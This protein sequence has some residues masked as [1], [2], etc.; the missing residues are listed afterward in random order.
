MQSQNNIHNDELI[1]SLVAKIFALPDGH[2]DVSYLLRIEFENHYKALLEHIDTTD[3]ANLVNEI[4][5]LAENFLTSIIQNSTIPEAIQQIYVAAI[6]TEV[7]KIPQTDKKNIKKGDDSKRAYENQI[8]TTPV[9]EFVAGQYSTSTGSP[10][11]GK[12]QRDLLLALGNIRVNNNHARSIFEN[13][14][15]IIFTTL[16]QKDKLIAELI[17]K[18]LEVSQRQVFDSRV[19]TMISGLGAKPF[20]VI[21]T[22]MYV[23]VDEQSLAESSD[24]EL[25]GEYSLDDFKVLPYYIKSSD[26]AERGKLLKHNLH[27]SQFSYSAA[28]SFYRDPFLEKLKF[29]G[30]EAEFTGNAFAVIG[31]NRPR[32]L[33][34]ARNQALYNEF[35]RITTSNFPHE[36]MGF[37]WDRIWYKKENLNEKKV[38]YAEARKFY[39][40]L[41]KVDRK[42]AE[43]FRK[44]NEGNGHIPYQD[45][46]DRLRESEEAVKIIRKIREKSPNTHVYFSLTDSDT[47]H[48]NGI[49]TEYENFVRNQSTPPH[50]MSTGYEFSDDV[51]D[52]NDLTDDLAQ[53]LANLS[54]ASKIDRAVRIETAKLKP[55]GVY[56]PEPNT[57]I[58]IPKTPMVYDKLPYTF[59]D[60]SVGN[61][62]DEESAMALRR[63][64][65]SGN[66]RF[67]FIDGRPLITALPF[68][69][70][71]RVVSGGQFKFSAELSNAK[72]YTEADLKNLAEITQSHFYYNLWAR[73]L[74]K[75]NPEAVTVGQIKHGILCDLFNYFKATIL[76]GKDK[77]TSQNKEVTYDSLLYSLRQYYPENEVANLY[78]AAK[79]SMDQVKSILVNRPAY[80]PFAKGKYVHQPSSRQDDMKPAMIESQ[81][82][83]LNLGQIGPKKINGYVLQDV[84]GDGNCFYYAVVEQLKKVAP[85]FLANTAGI[86]DYHFIRMHVQK[87]KFKDKEWADEN[88]FNSFVQNFRVALAI[89]DTR[90]PENGFNN[91][92]YYDGQKIVH[93]V[94]LDSLPQNMPVVKIAATGNHFLSVSSTTPQENLGFAARV[95]SE[96]QMSLSPQLVG[97][98]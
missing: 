8:S 37:F 51:Q 7:K 26:N 18:E 6:A 61:K 19:D 4:T 40:Q 39:K 87:D 90:Y 97:R 12:Y 14:L 44:Q 1:R 25:D 92:R 36:A 77:F 50:V 17:N 96:R 21:N 63:V 74:E 34:S 54:L 10:Q 30:W 28:P 89:I 64:V 11:S 31:L 52:Y 65:A 68:R 23:P 72:G 53:N 70:Y 59:L 84:P 55:T 2:E 32:S 42:S 95:S 79:N 94:S 71:K 62:G 27:K 67:A 49:Y 83:A 33:S 57:C 24:E 75:N 46:R 60:Y 98:R 38:T 3:P 45:I 82:Q 80:T 66:T 78:Y 41:K 81:M 56:Y 15:G 47:K 88:N 58:L 43:A 76:E 93:E 35:N 22:P 48:F 86:P 13:E 20:F 29:E 91:V 69:S 16:A 9:K 85:N 73:N 5:G